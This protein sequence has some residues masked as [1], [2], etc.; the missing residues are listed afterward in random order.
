MVRGVAGNPKPLRRAA[1]YDGF[2][3][4]NVQHP[5][6]FTDV[7]ATIA[8]LRQHTTAANYDIA[9]AL[10]IGVDPLPYVEAGATW[11]LP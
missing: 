5:R 1:G 10:P 9:V 7:V 8:D 3:P 6:Q 11:R 2:L 4:L